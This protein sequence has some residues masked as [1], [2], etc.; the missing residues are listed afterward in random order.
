MFVSLQIFA[1]IILSFLKRQFNDHTLGPSDVFK[2]LATVLAARKKKINC[3]RAIFLSL[4]V[5]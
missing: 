2:M 1:L 4:K 3:N 5:P